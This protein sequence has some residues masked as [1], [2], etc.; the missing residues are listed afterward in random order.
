MDAEALAQL[1]DIAL[2]PPVSWWPP[3]P[4]WW[5]LATLLLLALAWGLWAGWRWLRRNAPKRAALRQLKRGWRAYQTHQQGGQLV[6][7]LERLLKQTALS[8]FPREQVAPLYGAAWLQFLDRS[9][10]TQGFTRGVGRWLGEELFQAQLP[11]H[12]PAQLQ[13]LVDLCRDWIKRQ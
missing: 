6:R 13:A 3:A 4:G 2:P 5:M 10:R 11:S 12:Q 8:Y 7:E 9:G 1:Q